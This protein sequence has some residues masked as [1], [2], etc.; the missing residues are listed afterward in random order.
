MGQRFQRFYFRE[1]EKEKKFISAQIFIFRKGH[2]LAP[3][4]SGGFPPSHAMWPLYKMTPVSF[5]IFLGPQ[6]FSTLLYQEPF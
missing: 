1:E 3:V 2:C 6:L 4:T 5:F